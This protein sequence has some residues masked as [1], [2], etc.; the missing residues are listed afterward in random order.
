MSDIL[1]S[2]RVD[3]TTGGPL[4]PKEDNRPSDILASQRQRQVENSI[5]GIDPV[6]IPRPP[7]IPEPPRTSTTPP[8]LPTIDFGA[9]PTFTPP[10]II[11]PEEQTREIARQEFFDLVKNITINGQPPSMDGSFVSF[12]IPTQPSANEIFAEQNISIQP[13]SAFGGPATSLEI[14][15]PS[16]QA[17]PRLPAADRG[18]TDFASSNP[19]LFQQVETQITQPDEGFNLQTQIPTLDA[20]TVKVQDSYQSQENMR[21]RID[22]TSFDL[23]QKITN[24]SEASART[25]GGEDN[26][27]EEYSK[28]VNAPP[29]PSVDPP[30]IPPPNSEPSPERKQPSTSEDKEPPEEETGKE[31]KTDPPKATFDLL[32]KAENYANANEPFPPLVEFT[33]CLNGM[34]RTAVIPAFVGPSS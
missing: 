27:I 30:N 16:Q 14:P 15:L 26:L 5:G 12:N 19:D 20:D 29:Q 4:P 33:V 2:G 10:P 6:P 25:I 1:S 17:Q 8:P 13:P 31:E 34:A 3:S 22:E 7:E 21:A 28:G 11:R 24:Q 9:A 23:P 18:I 32:T